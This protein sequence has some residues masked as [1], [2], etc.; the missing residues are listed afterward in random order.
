MS[1]L[2][3]LGDYQL[4]YTV[5]LFVP[6]SSR[7][8]IL[9]LLIVNDHFPNLSFAVYHNEWRNPNGCAAQFFASWGTH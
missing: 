2:F 7:K 5:L 1:V 6:V 3:T 9:E 4:S 8:I